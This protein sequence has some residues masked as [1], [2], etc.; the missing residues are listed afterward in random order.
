MVLHVHT[1]IYACIYKPL[2][3]N[4][5]TPK[6]VFAL[7]EC[8][9]PNTSLHIVQIHCKYRLLSQYI[10]TS[11]HTVQYS[12]NT[13]VV[14]Y[15]ATA[16]FLCYL[17]VHAVATINVVQRTCNYICTYLCGIAAWLIQYSIIRITDLWTYNLTS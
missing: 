4:L 14:L 7:C 12:I 15:S 8:T 5:C 1:F 11:F 9:S 16:I 3:A 13:G 17:H 6:V 2:C 10:V